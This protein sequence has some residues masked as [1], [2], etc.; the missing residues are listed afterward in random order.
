MHAQWLDGEPITGLLAMGGVLDRYR[1]LVVGGRPVATGVALVGDSWA[2]TNPSAGRGLS[3]GLAHAQL[4]RD[5]VGETLHDPVAF[6]ERWDELTE[7]KVAPF[8]RNQIASD[9]IRLAQMRAIGDGLEPPRDDTP[10]A[11]LAAASMHDP[12]LFRCLLETVQCLALPQEVLGRPGLAEKI[13]S[14]QDA[15]VSPLPG[16]DRQQLLQLLVA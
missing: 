9:R 16:P 13:E 12:D 6:A 2:C 11:R 7:E 14:L 15:E 10:Q 4:L 8:Y 1:R 5:C 3:V